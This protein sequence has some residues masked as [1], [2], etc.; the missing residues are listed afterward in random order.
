LG[1]EKR[2]SE[3]ADFVS[4]R[5]LLANSF[6]RLASHLRANDVD[7]DGEEMLTL[8]AALELDPDTEMFIGNDR[9]N[10]LRTRKQ[11]A[12]YIV[13]DLE[14]EGTSTAGV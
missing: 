8:G 9:A 13:P 14:R 4:G 1:E 5:E 3:I 11:R 2:A 7:I 10:E 12:P 6:D